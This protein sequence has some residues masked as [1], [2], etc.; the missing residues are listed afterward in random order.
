VQVLDGGEIYF[1]VQTNFFS[2]ALGQE[3]RHGDL[4][5]SRGVIV[6]KNEDLLARFGL[7][8]PKADYGLQAVYVWPSGEI[9]F[10]TETG[11]TG[12]NSTQF[13]AGDLLSDQGYV[14][15][16][17]L[18]LLNSFAPMEDLSNFGLDALFVVT[19]VTPP[20]KPS[21]CREISVPP[22]TRDVSLRFESEGRAFQLLKAANLTGPW[23]PASPIGLDPEFTDSGALNGQPQGYYQLHSW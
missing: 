22:G 18:A 11:F 6:R 2:E 23:L 12:T 21:Q 3:I 17:N 5:S 20:P 13:L 9:W 7:A 1:S 15:C 10:S 8:D 4:L 14:V 16:R 19:D